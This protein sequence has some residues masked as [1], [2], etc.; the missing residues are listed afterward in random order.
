M[1]K[2]K[3]PVCRVKGCDKL[4]VKK[5]VVSPGFPSRD[6]DKSE[7][8]K[9]DLCPQHASAFYDDDDNSFSMGCEHV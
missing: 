2:R 6:G 7:P 9:L 5:V 3:H 8:F 1:N 4:A